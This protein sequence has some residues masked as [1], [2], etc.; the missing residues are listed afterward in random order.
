[1]Y[2]PFE[3]DYFGPAGF[4]CWIETDK[5][6]FFIFLYYG[7]VFTVIIFNFF[8]MFYIQLYIKRLERILKFYNFFRK[9]KG[10]PEK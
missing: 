1:M 2:R 7:I 5:A 3:I 4:W 10:K 8:G 6:E 9:T